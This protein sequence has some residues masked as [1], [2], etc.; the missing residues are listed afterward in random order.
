MKQSENEMSWL[1]L[2]AKYRT[3]LWQM[4]P[5]NDKENFM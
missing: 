4:V 2:I 5:V 3:F 1:Q